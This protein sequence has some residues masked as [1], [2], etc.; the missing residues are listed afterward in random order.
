MKRRLQELILLCSDKV[1]TS[2][3]RMSFCASK[4]YTVKPAN[5]RVLN[6]QFNEDFNLRGVGGSYCVVYSSYIYGHNHR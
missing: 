1:C 2:V 5:N 3:F 4:H 6:V